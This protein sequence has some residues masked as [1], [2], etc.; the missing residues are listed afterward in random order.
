MTMTALGKRALIPIIVVLLAL[1]PAV[2]ATA[3]APETGPG[4]DPEPDR[5]SPA[6]ADTPAAPVARLEAALLEN[7]RAGQARD[8]DQRM[9]RL[10]PL[11]GEVLD[12][13]RMGGYLFGGAWGELEPGQRQAFI[14][15]FGRL[16][17]ATYAARFDEFNGEA[18]VP[19]EVKTRGG[20]RAL[21]RRTLVTGDGDRIAFDYLLARES[22]GDWR[23]VNII[24]DGVSDL[25][26][27][28]S[29]YKGLFESG[30]IQA[31]IDHVEQATRKQRNG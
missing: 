25:A 6:V 12:I 1:A 28:R 4:G 9:Q 18:F 11:L 19:E 5:P 27:K 2:P 10:L 13:E 20:S 15:A 26:L 8:F 23:I 7:M 22:G 17:A 14:D 21:V 3:Q 30:G 31:V 24:T 16:S 29:Q